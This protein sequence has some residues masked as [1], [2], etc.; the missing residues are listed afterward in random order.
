VAVF[1]FNTEDYPSRIGLFFDPARPESAELIIDGRTISLGGARGL[2]IRRPQWP[3]PVAEVTDPFDR[4][5]VSQEAIAAMGGVWR[6]LRDRCVS[7]PDVMQAARWKVAQLRVAHDLGFLVPAT[8][9]TNDPG[10]AAA[11]VTGGETV[12]K[13]VAEGRVRVGDEER[14]GGTMRLDPAW[15]LGEVRAAP[16][17]LQR[18]VNKLADVRVTVIGRQ[19]FAV[20]IIAPAGSLIDV[21]LA[22]ATDCRYEVIDLTARLA[23]QL[24][25][26]LDWWGLRYGAFDLAEDANGA[27]WFLECNPAGQ[28]AWLEPFT[29]LNMTEALVDLLLDPLGARA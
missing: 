21:R 20:R 11:F 28:W 27:M 18:A 15:D 26:Y 19:L 6:A 22:K 25:A 13:A 5:L 10:R 7:P 8:V 4:V 16:V 12:I 24:L 9:I 14:Q 23:E 17:L 1:R 3:Q 2:W 29:G